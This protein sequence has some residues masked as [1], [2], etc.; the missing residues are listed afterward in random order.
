MS[1]TSSTAHDDPGQGHGHGHAEL[2][3]GHFHHFEPE[4]AYHAAKFGMWLFLATEILFFG[5]LFAAYAVFHSKYTHLFHESSKA[6]NPWLGGT[7]TVVLLLSSFS[8]ALGV[9][10]AQH[11][12]NK[13]VI[14]CLAFTLVCAAIFMG[15]KYIE[16]TSKFSHNIFPGTNLFFALYFCLTGLHG[17]HVVLGICIITWIMTLAAKNR[18]S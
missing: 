8:M 2:H 6:L 17:I 15:I 18:F 12:K 1:N 10:A 4:Q 3:P 11:G 5:G 9:D 16:Y 14:W 13:K 7:N